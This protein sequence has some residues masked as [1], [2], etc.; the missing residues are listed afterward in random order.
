MHY[1]LG[2]AGQALAALGEA[3]VNVEMIN[4]GASETSIMLAIKDV[5]RKRAIQALGE[6]YFG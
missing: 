2:N 5:D 6:S 1:A 3:G 4:M